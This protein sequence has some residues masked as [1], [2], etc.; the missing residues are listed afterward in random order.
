MAKVGGV[1][2]YHSITDRRA[3]DHQGG[4]AQSGRERAKPESRT[5][6]QIKD[7]TFVLG[8]PRAEFTPKVEEAMTLLFHEMDAL[9]WD[10]NVARQREGHL[11][12]AADQDSFLP[13]ASRRAFFRS[14]RQAANHVEQTGDPSTLLLLGLR[15]MES[16]RITHGLAVHDGLLI[17]VAEK[18]VAEVA[19]AGPIGYLGAATF[20]VLYNVAGPDEIEETAKILSA[21]L[22]SASVS[23]DGEGYHADVAWG[24]AAIRAGQSPEEAYY[25]ADEGLRSRLRG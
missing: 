3:A 17:A 5:E 24:L 6:E 10:L 15:D 18:L 21:A 19:D 14:L 7:A 11:L 13:V 1:Q 25:A 12:E 8:V 20:G 2:R 9:R 4:Y 23:R 16:L 22:A